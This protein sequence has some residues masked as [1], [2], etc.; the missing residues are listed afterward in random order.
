MLRVLLKSC[1][2]MCIMFCLVVEGPAS[3]AANKPQLYYL[4][5]TRAKKNPYTIEINLAEFGSKEITY[6]NIF[7]VENGREIYLQRTALFSPDRTKAVLQLVSKRITKEKAISYT[8]ILLYTDF[9]TLDHI[10]IAEYPNFLAWSNAPQGSWSPNN[11]HFS[12]IVPAYL[13]NMPELWVFDSVSL[14]TK[15]QRVPES[16]F[17]IGRDIYEAG[18]LGNQSLM[19]A[20][21]TCPSVK[22]ED[23]LRELYLIDATTNEVIQ[24]T[25]STAIYGS[26][27][28]MTVSPDRQY[29]AFVAACDNTKQVFHEVFVWNVLQN[30]IERATS[31]TGQDTIEGDRIN[32]KYY[33]SYDFVWIDSSRLLISLSKSRSTSALQ[34]SQSLPLLRTSL[35]QG[36]VLIDIRNLEK[37]PL[38][39]YQ[40]NQFSPSSDGQFTAYTTNQINVDSN[41]TYSVKYHSLRI[42]RFQNFESNHILQYQVIARDL[43]WAKQEDILYFSTWTSAWFDADIQSLNRVDVKSRTIT[44]RPIDKESR[45]S[46]GTGLGWVFAS[47]R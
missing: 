29:V 27:C 39:P 13:D 36:T 10:I 45:L 40:M 21:L 23:C 15:R 44:S 6:H 17:R 25:S 24:T 4:F 22:T 16:K 3:V 30:R 11:Q 34:K 31:S 14:S 28:R 47:I 26:I 20:R 32:I 19:F 18:W 5:G 8:T 9:S 1:V 46:D 35:T 12:F 41:D 2:S 42:M 38:A 37:L 33:I 7:S 43:L